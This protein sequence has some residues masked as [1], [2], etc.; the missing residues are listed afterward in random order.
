VHTQAG[1]EY[2]SRAVIVA[3]GST[4]R[5]LNVPGE[6]DFIGAGIHFCATCDGPFYK[7]A[8]ELVVLGGGN[9]GVEEGLFLSQFAQHITLIEFMPELK[10]SALLQE[11]V[12]SNSKFTIPTNTEVTE[13][14]GKSRLRTV[15]ARDRSTGMTIEIEPGAV[16]VFIGLSPNSGFLKGLLETDQAGFHQDRRVFPDL[17]AWRVR[18]GRCPCWQHEAAR[19]CDRRLYRASLG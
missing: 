11:E 9:S 15:V 7:G 3:T 12:R 16:F 18:G 4:Y 8:K 5:R 6:A 14:R 19:R 10:A 17:R 2:R 13:F 1:D